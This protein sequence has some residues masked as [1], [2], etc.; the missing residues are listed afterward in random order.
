MIPKIKLESLELSRLICGTNPFVGISH[1]TR[2][3]DMFLKEYF[4]IERISEIMVYLFEEFGVN[5]CLSSPREEIAK[6]IKIVQDE[7]G[8]KYHWLCTPSA[9]ITAKGL[10]PDIS[11]QIKWCAD[12]DVSVCMPHRSYTDSFMNPAEGVIEGLPD[13]LAEIRDQGMIPGISTHYHDAITICQ[14]QK[15]DVS[16]IIQPLNTIGFQSDIEVNTLVR[17]IKNTK[18]QIINIKPLAAGRLL[19]EVGLPFC[20]NNIKPND[21]V[22]CGFDCIQNADYDCQLV[23]R[24]LSK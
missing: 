2:S 6:A 5:C 13:I 18:F 3:R 12:H 16:V 1:F 23:D 10:K 7:T 24:L 14:K 8:E 15:Y 21:F 19:P 20:F 4:T 22:A 17:L 11:S 9:R